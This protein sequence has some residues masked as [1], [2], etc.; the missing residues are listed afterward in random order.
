[1][2]VGGTSLFVGLLER[3]IYRRFALRELVGCKHGGEA[4]DVSVGL[5][6]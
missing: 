1:M 3:R 2:A 4:G 6:T 5:P